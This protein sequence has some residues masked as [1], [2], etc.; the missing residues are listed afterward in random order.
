MSNR[1]SESKRAAIDWLE[2]IDTG[3]YADGW[4][5]SGEVFRDAVSCADWEKKSK[6]FL[7]S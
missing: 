5:N 7:T 6:R 4:N 1:I 3:Q 2:L